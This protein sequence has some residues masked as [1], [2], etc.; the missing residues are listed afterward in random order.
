MIRME[1]ACFLVI[2]FMS[3]IYFSAKREKSKLH[4][5]FSLFLIMSMVHLAFDGITIYTVNNMDTVPAI[6]NEVVH[7]FFIGTMIGTFYLICRYIG[8]LVENDIGRRVPIFI[9]STVVLVV[10]IICTIFLPIRYIETAKGN[11]SYGPVAFMLYICL[12]IYLVMLIIILCLHWNEIHNK[13]KITIS[14]ALGIQLVAFICQAIYPLALIS[15]MGVMLVNLAFYLTIENPDLRLVEQVQKE[16]LKADEANAAKSTFLS[17]MSHEIRTPMNAVVGMADILLKTDLTEEQRDYL[18]NIKNSG[19][20]LVSIIND[21]LDISKIE[22]GKMELSLGEYE[23]RPMLNDIQMIIQ[24]RIDDKP[25]ELIF[26]IDKALPNKL[27][28]DGFRIRQIFINL[29]NNAVKFTDR[30]SVKLVIKTD[31]ISQDEIMMRVTVAD[32]GQGIKEEDITRLFKAFEQVNTQ[33]NAGKEGTGLGLTISSQFVRMMGGQLEIKSRY[34][35]GSEFLFAIPQ[36]VVTKEVADIQEK[37]EDNRSFTAPGARILVVDDND[38]NCKVAK[39]LLAPLK[40]HIDIAKDGR[41]ALD[42]IVK[43]I[44]HLVFMDHMMPVMDGVEATQKLRAMEDEYCQTVPIIALSANAMKDAR[45]LFNA[46]GMN[47]FVAKPIDINEITRTIR[48]WLPESLMIYEGIDV[49][50]GIKNSGS[51]EL[52]ISLLGDFYTVIDSKAN[53]IE[54]YLEDN[55]IKDFTI[56]VHALKSTSR[57]IGAMEL[58]EEFKELEALGNAGDIEGIKAKTPS[59]LRHYRDYKEI[60]K[61]YKK[62]NNAEL[63][64]VSPEEIIIYLQGIQD[65]VEAFDLDMVDEAMNKLLECKVSDDC[66]ELMEELRVA[67]SDVAMEDIIRI[68]ESMKSV[69]Q[70][71]EGK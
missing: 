65:G 50:E 21:V 66:N 29:L 11:Y 42:M 55:L 10:G 59:V 1:I 15:G 46:A 27:Y 32:T 39:G 45:E 28:G 62:D 20:A 37:E 40:M 54:K 56:E 67:V 5:T 9:I 63:R 47:G 69:I 22:S 2:A 68:T 24:N 8:L 18:I 53:K 43:N 3:L 38:M 34:G 13:K 64:D 25:I 51:Q 35:E 44:Y 23:L 7:R 14:V 60:L 6:I 57:L 4:K 41:E 26:E 71:D 48:K 16:K 52:F 61:A 17:H 19:N 36:K 31:E 12:A 58:S 30:G 49:S 70:Q 33:K